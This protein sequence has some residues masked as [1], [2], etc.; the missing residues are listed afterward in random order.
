MAIT[1]AAICVKHRR[2]FLKHISLTSAKM[3]VVRRGNISTIT[4]AKEP[5]SDLHVFCRSCP[6]GLRQE[7][8]QPIEVRSLARVVVDVLCEKAGEH[9]GFPRRNMLHKR[10]G[11]LQGK[12]KWSSV[13]RSLKWGP[14]YRFHGAAAPIE[15][16]GLQSCLVHGLSSPRPR[17]SYTQTTMPELFAGESPFF[18]HATAICMFMGRHCSLDTAVVK[19]QPEQSL[20]FGPA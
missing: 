3:L 16:M 12:R 18:L 6:A 20:G 4:R 10:S 11:G 2:H 13:C 19:F 7:T 17:L 9:V 14:I 1:V 5:T 8:T 15:H